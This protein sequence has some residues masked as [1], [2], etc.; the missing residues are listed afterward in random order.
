[1]VGLIV[2]CILILFIAACI[3]PWWFIPATIIY[4]VIVEFLKK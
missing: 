1:M 3:L 2:W 4:F